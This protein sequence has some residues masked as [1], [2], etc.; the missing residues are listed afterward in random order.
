MKTLGLLFLFL[1]TLTAP[2]L[3]QGKAVVSGHFNRPPLDWREGSSLKGAAVELISIILTDLDIE[4]EPRHGGPW[5]RVLDMLKTG[6][7]DIMTGLYI[8]EQRKQFAVFTEPFFEDRISIFVWSERPFAFQELDDLKDKRFGEIIGAT[9]GQQFDKWL[10]ENAQ[11]QYLSTHNSNFKML[12]A[13]RIDCFVFSHFP[14]LMRIKQA[15][16]EGRIV[17]L[18]HPV[19]IKP[20][21][22]A[23]SKKSP[24]VHL[25]PQINARLLQLKQEGVIE[26]LI[27]KHIDNYIASHSKQLNEP[28]YSPIPLH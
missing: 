18:P 3:A 17:P 9:R 4:H 28:T 6:G 21:Y 12:E 7:V 8:N 23:V 16:F 1:L 25:V 14:G 5:A 13:N 24:L 10:K 11:V 15:G 22:F 20:L 2:A 26:Q 27:Q 19:T